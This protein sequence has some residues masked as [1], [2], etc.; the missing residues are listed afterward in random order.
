MWHGRGIV[1]TLFKYI[2]KII[3]HLFSVQWSFEAAFWTDQSQSYAL[4]Y[5][6]DY[7]Y[8]NK[9]EKPKQQDTACS[10]WAVNVILWIVVHYCLKQKPWGE[11]K[12]LY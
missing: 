5:H 6:N 2:S 3:L 12:R 8:M 9:S 4:L 10:L 1:S 11:S 7:Q